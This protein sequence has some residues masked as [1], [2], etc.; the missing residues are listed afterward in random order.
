MVDEGL[1]L[2]GEDTPPVENFGA[3]LT[4]ESIGTDFEGAAAIIDRKK[5]IGQLIRSYSALEKKYTE[6]S[7]A[8]NGTKVESP[9][10]YKVSEEFAKVAEILRKQAH[11]DGLSQEQFTGQCAVIG[12][13]VNQNKSDA[14]VAR[15]ARMDAWTASA[16]E[17][18]G[19]QY[20]ETMESVNTA[21]SNLRPET[22]KALKDTGMMHEPWIRDM[23]LTMNKEMGGDRV[24]EHIQE[25][26]STSLPDPKDAMRRMSEIQ[27]SEEYLI[28]ARDED[29]RTP[30]WK[31]LHKEVMACGLSAVRS[32]A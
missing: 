31:K 18:L 13:A 4:M 5:T 25:G 6:V 32:R 10:A 22:A 8:G 17:R 1:D 12:A 29:K 2:G 19:M 20:T 30:E 21:L 7:Q 28:G 24:L 15:Q 16:K 11:A 23:L 14:E 27:K 26:K 9:E 3:A